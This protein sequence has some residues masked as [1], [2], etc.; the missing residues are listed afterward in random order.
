MRVLA[1]RR[2][3][4]ICLRIIVSISGPAATHAAATRRSR[5]QPDILETTM[6]DGHTAGADHAADRAADRAAYYARIAK[7]HM[8]PRGSRCTTWCP[9]SLPRAAFPPSGNTTTCATTSWRPAH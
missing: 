6:P 2:L 3:S 5:H 1:E 7:K 4:R 8:A 9:A